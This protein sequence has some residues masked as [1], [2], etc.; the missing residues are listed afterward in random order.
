M[1]GWIV[2]YDTKK[3]IKKTGV[4]EKTIHEKIGAVGTSKSTS[5]GNL[6]LVPLPEN[7]LF[8]KYRMKNI[9]TE[10]FRLL[11][12]R[13]GEKIFSFQE[14]VVRARP[15]NKISDRQIARILAVLWGHGYLEKYAAGEFNQGVHSLVGLVGKYHGVHY[16]CLQFQEVF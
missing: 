1:P 4:G 15:N 8:V 12:R 10:T 5:D 9:H 2:N 13:F 11:K 16:K 6:Y 3:K 7:Y 14:A